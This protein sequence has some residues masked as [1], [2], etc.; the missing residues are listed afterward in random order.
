MGVRTWTSTRSAAARTSRPLYARPGYLAMLVVGG[1]L[2]TALRSWLEGRFVTTTG[3]CPWATFTINVAG[4][5]LLAMLIT[6]LARSGPDSGWRRRVRVGVGTGVLGG[7]TTYSTFIVETDQLL[8]GGHVGLGF[9]YAVGSVVTG[10]A[11]A[12]VGVLVA[13]RAPR[14]APLA[15]EEQV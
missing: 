12:F 8:R 4:S 9:A 6:T 3:G 11:A 1:G 14:V 2:G 10:V 7:F 5:L 13:R 15:T